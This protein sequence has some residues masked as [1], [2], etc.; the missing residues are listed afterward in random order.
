MTVLPLEIAKKSRLEI[1]IPLHRACHLGRPQYWIS[2]LVSQVHMLCLV[3]APSDAD[4][5]GQG[6]AENKVGGSEILYHDP[7]CDVREAELH[8][9]VSDDMQVRKQRRCCQTAEDRG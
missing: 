4:A 5:K 3:P 2:A 1:S 7:D 9:P 8:S 6:P